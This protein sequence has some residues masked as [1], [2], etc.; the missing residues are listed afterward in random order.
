MSNSEQLAASANRSW[1]ASVVASVIS[2]ALLSLIWLSPVSDEHDLAHAVL[3][4]LPAIVGAFAAAVIGAGSLVRF[5]RLSR[6]A[7]RPRR[8]I[9]I[10]IVALLLAPAVVVTGAFG[11]AFLVSTLT[12]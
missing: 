6:Q 3:F 10:A 8:R 9:E 7:Q 5:R 4:G 12:P 2:L 11:A 1:I